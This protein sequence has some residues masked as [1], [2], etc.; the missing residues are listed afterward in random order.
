MKIMAGLAVVLL[1]L[2]CVWERVDVVQVGYRIE[3]LKVKKAALERDR[4]ELQVKVSR[5]TSP[6][7]IAKLAAEKLGMLPPQ[8]GQVKLVKIEP[9]TPSKVRPEFRQLWLAKSTP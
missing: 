4:D 3:Q 6:D 1:V 2:L 8:Q 5:L 7:R 9:Q